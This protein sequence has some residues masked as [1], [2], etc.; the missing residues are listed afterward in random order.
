MFL[1]I[2]RRDEVS[3]GKSVKPLQS[4]FGCFILG[5]ASFVPLWFGCSRARCTHLPAEWYCRH[6]WNIFVAVQYF[7]PGSN[8]QLKYSWKSTSL[9]RCLKPSFSV[10]PFTDLTVLA[11]VGAAFDL[12]LKDLC[13]LISFGY[14][15]FLQSG[16]LFSLCKSRI[17][18]GASKVVITLQNTKTS[19]RKSVG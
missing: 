18:F 5:A 13:A 7:H 19:K 1:L 10:A 8:G 3:Q 4:I 9:W 2:S 11:P 16:E 14:D 6:G 12:D 17:S 15:R